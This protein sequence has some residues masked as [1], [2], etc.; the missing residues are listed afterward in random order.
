LKAGLIEE[1]KDSE[2]LI[3]GSVD[4]HKADK[5]AVLDLE[6]RVAKIERKPAH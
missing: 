2:G 6:R 1:I 5:T 3:V 4:K